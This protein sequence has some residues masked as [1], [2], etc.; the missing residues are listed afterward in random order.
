MNNIEI[1][2]LYATF[3]QREVKLRQ[4]YINPYLTSETEEEYRMDLEAYTALCY[5]AIED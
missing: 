3:T 5:G 2:N 1:E 4:K